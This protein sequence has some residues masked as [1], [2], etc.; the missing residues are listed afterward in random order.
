MN[1]LSED[2]IGRQIA[3]EAFRSR[4]K[5]P[6]RRA[7][8]RDW[9]KAIRTIGLAPDTVAQLEAFVEAEARREAR[10][11]SNAISNL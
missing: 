6:N 2:R 10:V 4:G 3:I 5:V 1:R 11:L 7:I 8:N 9:R